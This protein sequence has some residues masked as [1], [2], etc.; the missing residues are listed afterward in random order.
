[1]DDANQVENQ[2]DSLKEQIRAY[3]KLQK[4]A[5]SD[6]FNEY[7]DLLIKTAADKMLWCFT[8]GKDGDNIKTWDDFCKA[9]GEIVARLQPIQEV[10]GAGAVAEYMQQQLDSYYKKQL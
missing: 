4:V 3:R 6:D 2:A 5:E 1:M 9:R 10:H 7:F 8:T